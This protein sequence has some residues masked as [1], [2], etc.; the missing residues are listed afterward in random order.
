MLPGLQYTGGNLGTEKT[1]TADKGQR[2][3]KQSS[4]QSLVQTLCFLSIFTFSSNSKLLSFG[5]TAECSFSTKLFVFSVLQSSWVCLFVSLFLFPE[6][7]S[8]Y[9][10]FD[11]IV[12]ILI[13]F[14]CVLNPSLLCGLYFINFNYY[15][16]AIMPLLIQKCGR[17]NTCTFG[18]QRVPSCSVRQTF[19]LL[20]N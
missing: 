7:R 14:V 15:T 11:I 18:W 2:R 9:L 6:V 20:Y 19:S 12:C 5:S 16:F 10:L 1:A 8:C 3:L 17:M 4:G 13:Y